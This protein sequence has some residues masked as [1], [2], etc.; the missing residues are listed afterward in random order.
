MIRSKIVTVAA[1]AAAVLGGGAYALASSSAPA[2]TGPV[3]HGCEGGVRGRIIYD[4]YSAGKVPSCPA[5]A[6][7]V[8]WNGQGPAGAPGQDATLGPALNDT[9][10]TSVP[11]GGSF[12]TG[13]KLL[14]TLALPAGTYQVQVNFKATPNAVTA[15]AVFPSVFIYDGPQTSGF[16]NDL[17]NVGSGALEQIATGPLP[18]DLI[19]SYFSGS[20]VV[21]VPSSGETLD[22]YGFGYDSDT[23]GGTYAMDSVSVVTTELASS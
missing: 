7:Q 17:F 14:G 8:S 23:G 9:T 3:F 6:W 18:S 10:A 12:S 21:T 16:A 1:V 11:T 22:I 13:R 5:G 20:G 2:I 19:D 4:V 15:G